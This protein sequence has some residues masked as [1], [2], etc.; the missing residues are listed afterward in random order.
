MIKRTGIA[1]CA[2]ALL[3]A[4][5]SSASAALKS[6]WGPNDLP[7]GKS[8]FPTYERLGVDVLQVQIRWDRVARSRPADE[9]NT[10][11]LV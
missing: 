9:R 3:L 6:I 5:P 4:A 8:A 1:A 11:E 10:S 2:V 7:N